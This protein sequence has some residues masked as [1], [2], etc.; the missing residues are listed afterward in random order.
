MKNLI[1]TAALLLLLA[2]NLLAGLS[3][4][5]AEA[6]NE[7][8]SFGEWLLQSGRFPADDANSRL[9][10]KFYTMMIA[11]RDYPKNTSAQLM[12]RTLFYD[13]AVSTYEGKNQEA[14]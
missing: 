4:K 10:A 13:A 7:G 6:Y 12:L 14:P 1:L 9:D 11:S 8:A 2:G 5:E 3:G